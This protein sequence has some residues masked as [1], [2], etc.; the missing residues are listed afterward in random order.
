VDKESITLSSPVEYPYLSENASIVLLRTI[1]VFL[2]EKK[3]VLRRKVNSSSAQPLLE[4]AGSFSFDLDKASNLV[5][6]RL[7]HTT[8]K[9]KFY[10]VSVFPKNTAL[11][12]SR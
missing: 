8:N 7:A 12:R 5:K 6:L 9:E 10:E 3:Q 11:A 2:D 1:S 4:G